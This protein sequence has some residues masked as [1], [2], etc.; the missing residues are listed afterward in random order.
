MIRIADIQNA[1]LP[2]VGWHQDYDP[3]QQIDET[4][5]HSESGLYYQDAH[6]LMTLQNV[7]S[8]MPDGF[9]FQYQ[10]WKAD[11]HYSKGEKRSYN[12][13]VYKATDDNVNEQPDTSDK[14][15]VF[16]IVSDFI[17][18]Q[19]L[20]GIAQTVQTFLQIKGLLRESK[21]LLER[22]TFFDGAGRLTNYQQPQG[23]LVGFEINPVRAM[24]VT[25]KIER[26]GLQMV[27]ATGTVRVYLFH[28]SQVNPIYYQ[29][30]EFT[31]ENGGFQ[32]FDMTDWY[33]PYISEKNNSGGSWYLVYNQ[34]DLPEGM[35]AINAT[36][37]WSREPCMTCNAGS[38][39]AWRELTKYLRISPFK[40]GAL[41]T[42]DQY[43]EMWDIEDNIYT[44]TANYG[45]NVEVSVACDL[46][47]FIIDQR[48]IFATVLQR[49]VAA[50]M[51]RTMALNP[52]VRTN[53]NQSNVSQQ[54][55]LYE[56]DGNPQGRA[57]GIGYE[58][59]K[60]Y[61]ALDLD[62]RDIDRICLTCRP[63]GVRYRTV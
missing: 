57:T 3:Q 20:S 21:S 23:K 8:I 2:L 25:A 46:S 38:V 62:T 52:D 12:G 24:G 1:L 29:D 51:L 61:E 44:N 42:F 60:A 63:I 10:E 54:G 11:V 18:E 49:Q 48:D 13:V 58:L 27:G 59:K 32:W 56:L 33:M 15:E 9:K 14:W 43:P 19:T 26:I 17:K 6:P 41:E 16:N 37:D 36:K 40:V 30:L 47:Q 22:R 53:R 35:M 4:L 45:L 5:T 7:R 34:N 55:I 28:S 39:E 50:S 31:K